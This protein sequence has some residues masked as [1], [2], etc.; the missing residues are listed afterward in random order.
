MRRMMAIAVLAGIAGPASAVET[1]LSATQVLERL[2]GEAA[3]EW[4]AMARKLRH[5]QFDYTIVETERGGRSS[6]ERVKRVTG[7]V[8]GECFLITETIL[9]TDEVS[10]YG[11]NDRYEFA[12]VRRGASPWTITWQSGRG[13]TETPVDSAYTYF[14][15][16]LHLPWS[17]SATPLAKLVQHPRFVVQRARP[18]DGGRWQVDFAIAPPGAPEADLQGLASGSLVLD[19]SHHWAV[20]EYRARYGNRMS[21]AVSLAYAESGPPELSRVHFELRTTPQK[22]N[23]FDIRIANYDWAPAGSGEFTLPAFGLPDYQDPTG[24]RHWLGLVNLGIIL[25]LLGLIIRRRRQE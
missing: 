5:F 19:P 24:R 18:G 13:E 12:L 7:R 16:M 15:G 25:V 3:A 6:L 21:S 23:V 22:S 2:R 20:V 9:A 11:R 4:Q 17:I 14:C 8:E 10:V 1:S